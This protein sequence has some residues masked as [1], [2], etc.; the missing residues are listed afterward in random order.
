MYDTNIHVIAFSQFVNIYK[1]M[2]MC[3]VRVVALADI[4]HC[5]HFAGN[6]TERVGR[7]LGDVGMINNFP[8]KGRHKKKEEGGGNR[9]VL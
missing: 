6:A 1:Y 5:Q 3:S 2:Y 7:D 8:A 9:V 4:L